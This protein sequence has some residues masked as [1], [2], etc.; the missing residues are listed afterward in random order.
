MISNMVEGCAKGF[1]KELEVNGVGYRASKQGKNLVMVLGF[2]HQVIVPEIDG[3]TIDVPAPNKLSLTD[4]TSRRSVSLQP[5]SVKSALRSL[6]KA[7]A[8]SMWTRLSSAKRVRLVKA[9]SS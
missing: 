1:S 2:S 7:R 4:P 3:I 9:R 5:K 8:S 6:I